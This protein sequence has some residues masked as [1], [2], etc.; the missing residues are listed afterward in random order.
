MST[1]RVAKL[2]YGVEILD[3]EKADEMLLD[4]KGNVEIAYTGNHVCGT[5]IQYFLVT[6]EYEVGSYGQPT[7]EIDF[8]EPP[9]M[10]ELLQVAK[11]TF[12]IEDPKPGW[13]LGLYTG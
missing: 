10:D 4:P 3:E 13:H 1:E 9:H 8:S 5:E 12:G 7:Q 11:E 6:K 2:F